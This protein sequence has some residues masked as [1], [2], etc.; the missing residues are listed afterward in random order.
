MALTLIQIFNELDI[1]GDGYIT[2]DE[3]YAGLK[4]LGAFNITPQ[5]AKE[6]V[7]NSDLDNDGKVSYTG[8]NKVISSCN[9]HT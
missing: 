2:V 3:M 6:I 5:E 1:D 8:E 9:S 4:K 7:A